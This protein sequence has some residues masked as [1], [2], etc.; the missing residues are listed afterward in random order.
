MIKAIWQLNSNDAEETTRLPA[1]YSK[2]AVDGPVAT[3]RC[4]D[5]IGATVSFCANRKEW[6]FKWRERRD[7]NPREPRSFPLWLR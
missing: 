6:L 1:D 2:V 5:S 3:Q 7:S 4:V